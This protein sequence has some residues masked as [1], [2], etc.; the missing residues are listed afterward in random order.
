[1][2]RVLQWGPGTKV[3]RECCLHAHPH[4]SSRWNTV[5]VRAG[6]RGSNWLVNGIALKR[7]IKPSWKIE[8]RGR[9][10]PVIFSISVRTLRSYQRPRAP[11]ELTRWFDRPPTEMF[12]SDGNLEAH[13]L[14]RITQHKSVT[15]LLLPL[16]DSLLMG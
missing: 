6:S 15:T 2:Y 3:T 13:L 12:E 16:V 8:R 9:R 4:S 10:F 14:K 11:L 7:R 1:M 5:W